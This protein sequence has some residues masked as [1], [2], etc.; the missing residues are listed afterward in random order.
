MQCT[1][2]MHLRTKYLYPL[3]LLCCF[4]CIDIPEVEEPPDSGGFSLSIPGSTQASVV[5]GDS[6][7]FQVS[8]TRT[9]GFNDSVSLSLKNPPAG[10]SAQP[11]T[12]P[13]GGTSASLTV[14]VDA[15]VEPGTRLLTVLATS[16]VMSQETTVEL[17]VL[18]PG[19]P[20]VKWTS[21]SQGLV[22]VKDSVQLQVAVEGR[23]DSVEL[24]KG[25]TVLAR[26]SG[27][28]YQYTWDTTQEP[29]GDY[30]LTAR[31]TFGN[32]TFTSP[33]LTVTV[34]H[35]APTVQSRTPE[36]GSS[37]VSS[38]QTLQVRFSEALHASSV[39]D[40][41]VVVSAGSTNIAK[42]LSLSTDG[43]TLTLTPTAPLPVS[44]TVAI[45]LG[46]ATA[47]LTDLAGNR[48]ANSTS[49]A[50]S[51][52][53]WLPLGGPLSA[54]PGNTSAENVAMKVGV[55]GN[56]V[57]AWAEPDSS[58]VKNIYARRWN[59]TGW[60]ALG[61][62]LS[63]VNGSTNADKP[64]L[65]I[66]PENQIYLVWQEFNGTN[67]NIYGMKWSGTWEAL[68][69]FGALTGASLLDSPAIILNASSSPVVATRY[70]DGAASRLDVFWLNPASNF[71][72]IQTHFEQPR[73]VRNA[74][75]V[76]IAA[77]KNAYVAAYDVYSDTQSIRGI[78]VQNSSFSS[79]S[80]LG[81]GVVTSPAKRMAT[82]PS[83]ALDRLDNP[84]IAW[85]E[86]P[87]GSSQ[88]GCGI[89]AAFWDDSWQMLG[90]IISS[91]ST[92]ST[93][94]SLVMGI[95]GRPIV[96]WSGFSSTER[97]IWVSRWTG[98]A[99]QTLG[100]PLS[101]ASGSSTA[102]FNPVLALDKNGRALV[103]WQES[104]GVVSNIYVYRYND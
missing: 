45:T 63:G 17:R 95:D 50:F 21:P 7:T 93:S 97:S 19:D 25:T 16:G 28:S 85:Q 9:E 103:A 98:S 86:C 55:D 79:P 48:V 99:W 5:Q 46:T 33:V 31:A 26:L 11:V 2:V 20:L 70:F 104:D 38:R 57:V 29:E 65:A 60:E 84:Y 23:A 13:A 64:A 42:T 73:S 90:T 43:K 91:G 35:T 94:P 88:S 102:G 81:G 49:W 66:S 15:S 59:G 3:L 78:A 89:Y 39:T 69:A 77:E 37:N 53:A 44:S 83:L 10:I 27:P 75:D 101:A 4:G 62:E 18:R 52:P 100:A 67:T 14:A 22:Y 74:G 41:S 76:Q 1:N 87:E 8:L 12:I 51:V 6:Y 68:P 96:A 30:A 71:W 56:P 80:L 32:A 36:T 40:A 34:D 47:P 61:I 82:R 54:V 24:L 92:D 58:G 72:A